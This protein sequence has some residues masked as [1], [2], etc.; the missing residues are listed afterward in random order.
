MASNIAKIERNSPGSTDL[1]YDK[2]INNTIL[3]NP[4]VKIIIKYLPSKIKM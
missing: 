3:V 4:K 2:H 1:K